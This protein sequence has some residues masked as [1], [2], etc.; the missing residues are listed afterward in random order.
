MGD[1]GD[2]VNKLQE[3]SDQLSL[4]TTDLQNTTSKL[5]TIENTVN[6]NLRMRVLQIET[7]LENNTSFSPW[8]G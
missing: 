1:Q 6:S 7:W 4:V 8:G 5:Q 2:Q 3:V